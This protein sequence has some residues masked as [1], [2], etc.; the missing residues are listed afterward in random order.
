V[1]PCDAIH[2]LEGGSIKASGSYD[3]LLSGNAVFQAM[4]SAA[5][6]ERS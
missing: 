4:A 1:R 3:E 6:E 2:L 5:E